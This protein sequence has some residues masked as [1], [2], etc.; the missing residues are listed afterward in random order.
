[1]RNVRRLLAVA[2]FVAALVLGWRFADANLAPV[3]V[4]YLVGA[5]DGV[6][7]WAALVGSF[8]AGASLAWIATLIPLAR[9]GL[10]ARRW[11]KVARELEAELHQ[12]RNLPLASSSESAVRGSSGAPLA[13][14][15]QGAADR[16]R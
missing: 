5:I 14:A 3:S 9:L 8:L 1:M 12:L 13:R 4:H 11:R 16:S 2:I 6:P 10:T 7:L 15:Q